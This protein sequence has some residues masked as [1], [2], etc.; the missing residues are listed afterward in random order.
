M[1]KLLVN[2]GL[3]LAAVINLLPTPGVLGP[4][5]LASLYGFPVAGADLEIL[6]RHRAVLFGLVGLLLLAAIVVPAFRIPALLT[7][8]GSMG[9]FIIIALI[10]G[11]YGAA[12]TRVIIA[13]I[14]GLLALLPAA[15]AARPTS[16]SSR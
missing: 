3:L 15:I 11:G 2:A 14:V 12:I 4:A 8:A 13:D 7:A 10:V 16:A 1:P 9:S 5:W 6:L